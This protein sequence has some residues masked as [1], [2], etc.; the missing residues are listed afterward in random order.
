M[1]KRQRDAE[2][3]PDQDEIEAGDDG[4]V[5]L[6]R[7][8]KIV[9]YIETLDRDTRVRKYEFNDSLFLFYISFL[10]SSSKL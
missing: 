10:L 5:P 6:A 7:M 3:E 2:D 8:V 4:G 9:D 1:N